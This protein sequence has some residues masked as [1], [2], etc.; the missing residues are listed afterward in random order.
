MSDSKDK[1]TLTDFEEQLNKF[2]DNEILNVL[3]D[4]SVLEICLL[5]AMKH[6]CDIYDNQIMNFE[7]ICT[8]FTKFANSN[9][10]IQN[11]QRAILMKAFEHIQVSLTHKPHSMS[12]WRMLFFKDLELIMPVSQDGV[13]VQKEYR[14][15]KLLL[16][17]QL[18]SEAVN[19]FVGLP[20]E[21][22]QWTKSSII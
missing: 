10:N 17:P 2:E 19:K 1:I 9:S 7:M 15:F 5:I 11:A 16:Q 20:T 12:Q 4:L 18:I 22:I 13:R 3:L 8:R 21:V 14:M 6:H